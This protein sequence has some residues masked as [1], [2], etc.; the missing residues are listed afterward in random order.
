MR[1][2]LIVGDSKTDRHKRASSFNSFVNHIERS[3][4]NGLEVHVVNYRDVFFNNLPEIINPMLNIMLFFP[5][6]YWKKNN[7]WKE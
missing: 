7:E 2:L 5:Y 3:N 4:R 6:S 1:S